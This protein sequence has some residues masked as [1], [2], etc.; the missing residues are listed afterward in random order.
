MLTTSYHIHW[1][2]LLLSGVISLIL[3]LAFFLFSE[4]KRKPAAKVTE[5]PKEP[6]PIISSQDIKSIAGD[7]VMA[8]QLDLARAYIEMGK[9]NLAKKI[10]EHVLIHGTPTQQQEAFE[11]TNTL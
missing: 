4:R 3:I 7:D 8:T 5:T 10:L 9:K 1:P 11:L 6:K 2:H